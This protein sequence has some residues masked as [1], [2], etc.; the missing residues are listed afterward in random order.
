MDF[1]GQKCPACGRNFD[2]SYEWLSIPGGSSKV[3]STLSPAIS[4]TKS[5]GTNSVHTTR[6]LSLSDSIFPEE[7]AASENTIAAQSMTAAAR[8]NLVFI[9]FPF[10]A[11]GADS[12]EHGILRAEGEPV[13][14]KDM[15]RDLVEKAALDMEQL[16]AFGAFEMIV[17]AAVRAVADILIARALPVVE[18]ELAHATLAQHL[19]KMAIDRSFAD[20]AAALAQNMRY[21]LG[22]QMPTAAVF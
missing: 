17:I 3:K 1:N 12:V 2:R 18:H 8:K 13:V 11:L 7:Q 14:L 19:F 22:G 10:G 6:S 9:L 16:P 21:I 4:R 15:L 20:R 5:Y